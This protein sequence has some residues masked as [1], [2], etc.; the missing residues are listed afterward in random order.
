MIFHG[1]HSFELHRRNSS[2]DLIK[3]R[4]EVQ[5]LAAW[6]Q[7]ARGLVPCQQPVSKRPY[8][9]SR[10]ITGQGNATAFTCRLAVSRKVV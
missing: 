6:R 1:L 10:Y 5:V 7:S 3:K 2:W 9:A 4:S 8:D